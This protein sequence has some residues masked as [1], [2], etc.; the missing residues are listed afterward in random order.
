MRMPPVSGLT[1][2][3]RLLLGSVQLQDGDCAVLAQLTSLTA[4]DVSS[5]TLEGGEQFQQL[6]ALSRLES[7]HMAST[8]ATAPPLLPSLTELGMRGCRVQ[9]E[10][11]VVHLTM[12]H[13]FQ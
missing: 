6:S 13:A 10:K 9:A 4:L 11:A 12:V 7:L 5:D 1:R 8:H 3:R 2:L